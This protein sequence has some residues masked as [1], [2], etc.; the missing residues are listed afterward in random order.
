MKQQHKRRKPAAAPQILNR[1]ARFDYALEDELTAGLVLTGREVRAARDGQVQLKGAFVSIRNHELWLNNAS[2]S[3]K[4]NERG[5]AN[6]RTIDTSPKKLLVSSKERTALLE[7]KQ[8]GYSIIPIK[9]LTGDRFIKL[10]IATGKGK[11]LHDK[12]ETIKRRD[13]ERDAKRAMARY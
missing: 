5:N 11:K 13:S 12:R 1:R 8:Q 3:L 2:F 4:L 9:L 10:V 7:K 6:A